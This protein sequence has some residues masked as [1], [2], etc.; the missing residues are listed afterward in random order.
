MLLVTLQHLRGRPSEDTTYLTLWI[1]KWFKKQ[2]RKRRQSWVSAEGT[3]GSGKSCR[4]VR[5]K[6]IELKSQW[7][8]KHF[9][10]KK[11]V[12]LLST[13]SAV[14]TSWSMPP[15]V[16]QE[17]YLDLY[18]HLTSEWEVEMDLGCPFCCCGAGFHHYRSLLGCKSRDFCLQSV[19]CCFLNR[20]K[21][22]DSQLM[23]DT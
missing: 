9:Y 15:F 20:R 19:C 5:S 13:A 21:T 2:E 11:F 22:P 10:N 16:T 23:P 1:S 7:I 17:V 18:C 6:E 14:G 8:N 3:S 4:A 12:F